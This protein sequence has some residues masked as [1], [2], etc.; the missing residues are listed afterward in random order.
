MPAR[1]RS[2][3]AVTKDWIR[4]A[5]DEKA[6]RNGCRFDPERGRFVIDWWQ[7]YL[8]L[9]EGDA[10]A[11]KPF[12]ARDWQYECTMR[13]FGWIRYSEQWSEAY[14]RETWVRRFTQAAIFVPKK[15]KKSPTL[16]AYGLYLL[17]G[18]GERGQHVYFAARDGQ[19]AREIAGKH[20]VEMLKQSP[21]LMAECTINKTTLQIAHIPTRSTLAPISSADARSQ[22]SKEGLNGCVLV[23]EVHV[24]DRRFMNRV[25]R[26]GISRAEPM[27]IEVS[28]AGSNPD[29]Y[30]KD[31]YDY[32]MQVRDGLVDDQRLFFESYAAPQDLGDAELAADPV[33][34]GKLANPAWGHTISEDEYLSDFN[35]SR[36]SKVDLAEFKMYRLNIWQNSTSPWLS[37][38]DWK[39]CGE[40]FTES[41]LAG[42]PCWIG[43]DLSKTMDMTAAVCC[44]RRGDEFY[45]LPYFWL[46]EETAV[47]QNHLASFLRWSHEG[48][49]ELTPGNVVDYSIVE[50]KLKQLAG[51]FRVKELI[52][53]KTYAEE[54]TQRVENECGVTR[55]AF[56]QTIMNFAGPTAEFERLVID[57]KLRHPDHPVLTWQAGHVQ[58]KM[59]ANA[60]KRPVKPSDGDVKKIDGIVAAIMALSRA[61]ANVPRGSVYERRG[62]IMVG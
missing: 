58:V 39:N 30:G 35:S 26:A 56:P 36:R 62:P 40:A 20:S 14:G 29:G 24:V 32:G 49:L 15:N 57:G 7:K 1:V 61:V 18:D 9:Y 60:N 37:M 6:A 3:D 44:F 33:K 21:E 47:R 25:S 23:D 12:E 59:D 19:Q 43:L 10:W 22:E 48:Y 52:F 4:N 31:R 38:D 55:L 27:Q 45:L 13:M 2:I 53:D 41:D 51:T 16:A 8:R 54:L 5:S 28:T 34:F 50:E 42:E 11:G 17:C 46:P